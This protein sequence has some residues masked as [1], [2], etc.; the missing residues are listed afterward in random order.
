MKG[1]NASVSQKGLPV[2]DILRGEKI[3][4]LLHR[5]FMPASA[6]ATMNG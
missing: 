3:V 6:I 1:V 4:F 5:E 2:L